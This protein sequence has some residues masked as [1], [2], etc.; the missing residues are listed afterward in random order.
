M[1]LIIV[2]DIVNVVKNVSRMLL[3]IDSSMDIFEFYDSK[4]VIES[5]E[6]LKDCNVAFL[7]INMPDISGIEL[8]RDLQKLN[9][10]I[11][12]IFITGYREYMPDAFKIYASAYIEKPITKKMLID[13]LDHLRYPVYS[14]IEEKRIRIQCFGNFEVFVNDSPLHFFRKKSKELFAYLVDRRGAICDSD[15]I[16]GNLWP[17]EN[18]TSSLKSLQRMV[19]TDMFRSL[20]E[21]GLSNIVFRDKVGLSLNVNEVDCDYYKY[22]KGSKEPINQFRGEYMSQYSFAENTRA[23][24]ERNYYE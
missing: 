9:P 14:E 6:V 15:M 17:D 16:I 21:Y 13:A 4:K 12:I 19:V 10:K 23:Y 24:L 7:D 2:D 5:K 8:A 20:N 18:V 1:N 22:L 3:E 11:N